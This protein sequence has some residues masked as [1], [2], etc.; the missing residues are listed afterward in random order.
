MLEFAAVDH[1][2]KVESLLA[3]LLNS[4]NLTHKLQPDTMLELVIALVEE[5]SALKHVAHTK[6]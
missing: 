4:Y 1:M 2:P 6:G 3:S 5:V